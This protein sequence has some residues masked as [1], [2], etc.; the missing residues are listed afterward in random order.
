MPTGL[1]E[2]R[3]VA[4]VEIKEVNDVSDKPAAAQTVGGRF[5]VPPHDLV[6]ASTGD[7]QLRVRE[8]GSSWPMHEVGRNADFF[9]PE[10]GRLLQG[11][12]ELGVPVRPPALERPRHEG[13]PRVRLQVHAEGLQADVQRV[14][15]RRLSAT[16][17]HRHQADGGE[18]AAPRLHDAAGAHEDHRRSSRTCTRRASRMC[19]EAIWGY[20]IQ[21]LN[22]VG[23]DHNWVRGYATPTMRRRCCRRA[24]SS[25]SS[26]TW[27][28]RRRTGTSP[29]R[30]T[31]RARATGRSPTCSSTSARCSSLTDEQFQ[32]EM[33]KRREKLKL[34]EGQSCSA[35][36]C[37]R[38]AGRLPHRPAAVAM[39][40]RRIAPVSVGSPPRAACWPLVASLAVASRAGAQVQ[41]TGQNVAPAYEGWEQNADGSFNLRLRL[42]EP[43]LGRGTRRSDRPRQQHRAGRPGSGPAD[44]FLPRRNRFLVRVR[45]PKDF[46]DKEWSGR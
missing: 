27:T 36:R 14:R 7:G 40:R 20:N 46:G 30:A 19:L 2:D 9:D 38:T 21:T 42:H 3:Y 41:S 5:V 23:Y 32:E 16:A 17:R 4:A 24:R 28:T 25:T 31:G 35:A 10:A 11:R 37:A 26:A 6:R 33:A 43:E 39:A 15:G 34:K 45:V 44:A 13:A 18:P 1:T 29:I 8:R 12:L 22:C